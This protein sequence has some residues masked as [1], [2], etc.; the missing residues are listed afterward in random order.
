MDLH[1]AGGFTEEHEVL[2]MESREAT[3][4]KKVGLG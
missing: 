3:G 1:Q 4:P 2:V